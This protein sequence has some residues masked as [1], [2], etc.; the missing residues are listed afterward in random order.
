MFDNKKISLPGA[1]ST[2]QMSAK[3]LPSTAVFGKIL[4]IDTG[5]GAGYGGGSGI[6]G[7]LANGKDAIY[8]FNDPQ[9]FRNYVKGGIWSVLGEKLFNPVVGRAGTP[10]LLFTRAC[11][12]TP[13]TMTF[14]PTGGG[15]NGGSVVMQIQDEGLIGNGVENTSNKLTKGYAFTFHAGVDDINKF[16]VKFW[17]GTFKGLHTDGLPFDEI[18]ANDTEPLLLAQSI[19][20]NNIDDFIN[21]CS[22]DS[23]FNTYFKVLSSTKNGTGAITAADLT[24]IS[25]NKLATGGTETYSPT[26]LDT[27]FEHI[28]DLEFTFILADKSGSDATGTQNTSI[29][30]HILTQAK[31]QKFL[32][33]GGG[34]DSAHWTQTGGSIPTAEYFDSDRVIIVH[35][36]AKK[37]SLIAGSGFRV[38]N[39]LYKAACVLGR[40]CGLAPQ[41]PWT[42][43]NVG[44]D[45]EV[46][47]LSEKERTLALDKGV[48][49][50]YYNTTLKKYIVQQAVNTLQNNNW[51]VN[52]AGKSYSVQLNNIVAQVNKELILDAE[53]EL[54]ADES[55][56]NR[57]T[58]SEA[59]LRDWIV[60]KLQ[61]KSVSETQ[62]NY[63]ISFSKV[64]V[65]RQGDAYFGTYE[66]EINTEINKVFFTGRVY[67]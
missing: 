41:V 44:I 54:L 59:Y 63:L 13:A 56:V 35:G 19:E 1:Y 49:C 12:T 10:Q 3:Q 14:S 65:E 62:D 46:H 28:K 17:L 25:G 26:H 31:Y 30:N 55:G 2:V 24:L 37:T 45:G 64:V 60:G 22:V 58:L 27:V 50:T 21:W 39:S 67:I 57:N 6:A 43:K 33:V 51:M 32:V 52:A 23:V 7:V 42:Y 4:V 5:S 29:L 61:Q 48:L 8:S 36:A 66:M 11:A 53:I 18:S 40:G 38:F 9:E 16:F 15:A 34:D 47:N 20:F